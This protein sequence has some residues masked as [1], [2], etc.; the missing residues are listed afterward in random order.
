MSLIEN[1]F[2]I[3]LINPQL[4][5]IEIVVPEQLR[6][7][8]R[9]NRH[10]IPKFTQQITAALQMSFSHPD[11]RMRN[12]TRREVQRRVQLCYEAVLACYFDE[13]VSLIQTLDILPSVLLDTLR[14][15]LGVGDATDG[16]GSSGNA[17]RY[18]VEHTE[19]LSVADMSRDIN[20]S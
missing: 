3:P 7:T 6:P 19:A 1:K 4:L 16:R 10:L 13:K 15:E 8:M 5:D 11:T 2:S 20:R 9:A 14:M 18:G 12:P 17:H